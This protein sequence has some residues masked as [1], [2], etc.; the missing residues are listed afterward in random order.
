MLLLPLKIA[1][2]THQLE[3]LKD[4][5]GGRGVV[6]GEKAVW[7]DDDIRET[8]S[9]QPSQSERDALFSSFG[10]QAPAGNVL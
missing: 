3:L 1:I 8:A 9:S 4:A 2:D 10:D 6:T 7:N 5:F